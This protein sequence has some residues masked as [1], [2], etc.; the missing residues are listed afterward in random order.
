MSIKTF[1]ETLNSSMEEYPYLPCKKETYFKEVI[2]ESFKS[3]VKYANQW[4]RI[5][6]D[7]DG[8]ITE[9]TA[10]EMM[11]SL[12]VIVDNGIGFH[13]INLLDGGSWIPKVS[14]DKSYTHW[15]PI[16]R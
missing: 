4:F 1:H 8:N 12:P 5:Y 14:S 15:K 13:V 16:E 7:K 6:R 10:F 11:K 3:G 9:E 2:A